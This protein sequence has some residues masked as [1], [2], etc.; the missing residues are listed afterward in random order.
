[1]AEFIALAIDQDRHQLVV[2][3]L[4][5]RIGID[6]R[7]HNVEIR[8]ARLAAEEFQCSEHVVAKMAVVAAEQPQLRRRPIVRRPIYR[9]VP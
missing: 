1:M 5:H 3:G 7:H 2:S 8:H 4:E 6:I 9:I